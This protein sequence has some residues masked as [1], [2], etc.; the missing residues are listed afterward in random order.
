M[1]TLFDQW[2]SDPSNRDFLKSD[3]EKA[4]DVDRVNTEKNKAERR[5]GLGGIL[6][7]FIPTAGGTGG[8]LGGAA[9]G[10]AL[11]SVVP[12]VGTAIGGLAG[13]LLGGAGGS[14]LGK[15]VQ[16]SLEGEEDLGKGVAEEALIGGITSLPFGAGLKVAK[17][18]AQAAKG[19]L[20]QTGQAAAKQTLREAGQRTLPKLTPGIRE[21]AAQE[22]A[23]TVPTAAGT[24][25]PSSMFDRIGK[26]MTESGSGLKPEPT[27]GGI[28]KLE[29]Q[30]EFMSK[31]TGTPRQQRVAME[32]DMGALSSQ[33][34][35]ILAKNPTPIKGTDVRMQVQQAIDDPLKYADVDLT[36]PGVQKNLNSHLTKFEKTTSAKELND[37]IKQLNP[38]ARRAQDKIAR[39]VAV[40]DKEAAALTAKRAGDEVL[41]A[42]PEIKPLKQNMAQIFEVTPQVAKAGEQKIGLPM[43]TG[44]NIKGPVQAAKGAQSR[45]GALLQGKTRKP[46]PNKGVDP[47]SL[48]LAFNPSA[49][50]NIPAG[51]G[52][53]GTL[54]RQSLG[55]ALVPEQPTTDEALTDTTQAPQYDESSIATEG[56]VPDQS[57]QIQ[58]NLQQAAL[59]A[60]ANG[61]NKGLENILKVASLFE[62][63]SK[64]AAP[65]KKTET[66]RARDEAADLTKQSL[67]LLRGGSVNVG[68][69]AGRLE[70]FKSLFNMADPESYQFNTL[71]S[72]LKAAIAKARAGT[73]FTEGEKQ[74]LEKYTPNTG[75]SEQQ[76]ITKLT[77]LNDIYDRAVEREY[78]TQYTEPQILQGAQ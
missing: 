21:G 18:G 25:K 9:L 27:T 62:S 12:G 4:R 26:R 57:A 47:D 74:M 43:A 68:P 78:G 49:A 2:S 29:Q 19:A 53:F 55:R 31:Y 7:S 15:G 41:S 58:A 22:V 65:I 11:G 44:V 10:A 54:T 76:L 38:I 34:D 23:S 70:D 60:L 52:V 64:S 40:T 35:N 5:S 71:A 45:I 59:Q 17:A 63:S 48:N 3:M 13:A 30:A 16:N 46:T 6:Q 36:L 50:E 28:G 1:A 73:S 66:Q 39:G 72:S 77:L 20:R 24:V 67:E 69:I 61:D 56:A 8:A 42:I 32:K 33:V 51:Q 75:D 37:Y 14:A